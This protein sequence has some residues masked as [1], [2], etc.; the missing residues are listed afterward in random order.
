MEV[1][2]APQLDLSTSSRKRPRG[3]KSLDTGYGHGSDR[4]AVQPLDG[5]GY[6]VVAAQPFRKNEVVTF[7]T[8]KECSKA[9]VERLMRDDK[10]YHVLTVSAQYRYLDGVQ[11]ADLKPGDGLMSLTNDANYALDGYSKK[12]HN[13]TKLKFAFDYNTS[14]EV[15]LLVATRDIAAG[16]EITWSY[17]YVN[18]QAGAIDLQSKRAKTAE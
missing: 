18:T 4:L 9:D 6:G 10:H 13:N 16:E 2:S 3:R 1:V 17:M 5:R 15:P 11:Y 7:Y 12:N 8:G 14:K